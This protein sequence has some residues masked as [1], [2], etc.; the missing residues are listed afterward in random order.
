MKRCVGGNPQFLFIDLIFMFIFFKEI[1]RSVRV[2]EDRWHVPKARE[3]KIGKDIWM[4]QHH[5]MPPDD[6]DDD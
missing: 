5:W 6:L 3:E 1:K 4:I 2:D